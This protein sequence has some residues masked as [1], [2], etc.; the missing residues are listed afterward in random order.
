MAV[1]VGVAAG[2]AMRLVLMLRER[3]RLGVALATREA[4]F[5]SLIAASSDVITVCN[6]EG[7]VTYCSPAVTGVL[8]YDPDEILGRRLTDLVHLEDVRDVHR[9]IAALVDGRSER[10]VRFE[11]RVRDGRGNWIETE[12]TVT[13]HRDNA[14][15]NGLVFNTRDISDR[16]ALEGRV[17]HLVHHDALTDLPNRALFRDRIR[18]V[19]EDRTGR[20]R[21]VTV[22]VVDLDSFKTVNEAAGHSAGDA[23]LV[24]CARRLRRLVRGGDTVARL[25]G[26]AFAVLLEAEDD[27]NGALDVAQRLLD[28]LGA[29]YAVAGREHVVSASIGVAFS[30]TN[31]GADELLV[32][33]ELALRAAK[34]SGRNRI[35]VFVPEMHHEAVRRVELEADIR[36][37]LTTGEFS[38]DYQPILDLRQ[39]SVVGVEA[40][41]RWNHPTR[42]WVP[43][44][45]VIP[46]AEE[47][48]LIVPLGRWILEEACRQVA[49]WRRAGFE[50]ELAVNL[51]ARQLAAPGLVDAVASVLR[52]A[53]LP[54][55]ALT[56]EITEN[57][58][59]DTEDRTLGKLVLL[60]EIGVRLAIDDFGTGYS[61]LSYLQRLPVD[62][63]KIDRSYVAG[64][65]VKPELTSLT[66][67]IIR[68]GQD[69]GLCVVAEGIE[70]VA[71]RDQ[72]IEMGC[73]HGQGYLFARPLHAEDVVRM[74]GEFRDQGRGRTADGPV[75]GP[76]DGPADEAADQ[77]SAQ[78]FRLRA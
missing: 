38:L 68:L 53:A 14:S 18:H 22:L 75:H 7:V 62:V 30:G 57:V 74:L 78:V 77:P 20:D 11:C 55:S 48:G 41:L 40:L 47:S 28:A 1:C 54:A 66:S 73:D 51:S 19:L 43:P 49:R 15:V 39:G 4:H 9:R 56:L 16:A 59:V 71:Q 60:R 52:S 2:L 26:D 29:P 17:T 23:L 61:S 63:L 12:S 13:D 31:T 45:E 21:P 32:D 34:R 44:A 37:A 35:E 27:R 65:G 8:G 70:E 58:L 33:A 25:D 50:L 24:Q 42:G 72:L 67:T 69:L 36:R 6:D 46:V 5:E 10:A 76:V 3:A 64:V